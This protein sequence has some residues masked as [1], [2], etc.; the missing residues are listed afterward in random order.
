MSE[1]DIHTKLRQE[2][3]DGK[4]FNSIMK[5]NNLSLEQ[6][7]K[8]FNKITRQSNKKYKKQSMDVLPF[9]LDVFLERMA[10]YKNYCDDIIN[11]SLKKGEIP[12]IT[13]IKMGSDI[14]HLMFQTE[15]SVYQTLMMHDITREEFKKHVKSQTIPML[16]KEQ[17]PVF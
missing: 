16:K 9:R 3:I 4:D 13:F 8:V 10:K 7:I 2:I 5:E 6:Y 14:E 1:S 11:N 12:D 17:G 15:N